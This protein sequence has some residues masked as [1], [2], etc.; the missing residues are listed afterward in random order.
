MS[1]E[2]ARILRTTDMLSDH[3]TGLVPVFDAPPYLQ[4]RLGGYRGR[5]LHDIF[6]QLGVRDPHTLAFFEIPSDTV[7]IVGP[8][9]QRANSLGLDEYKIP[10]GT[11]VF[12]TRYV[13]L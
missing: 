7:G 1:K 13:R 4:E 8:I 6:R 2:E 5:A 10:E 12:N 11:P 9:P 3:G